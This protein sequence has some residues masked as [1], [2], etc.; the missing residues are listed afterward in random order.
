MSNTRRNGRPRNNAAARAGI[1]EAYD[2]AWWSA[3]RNVMDMMTEGATT[4]IGLNP[5]DLRRKALPALRRIQVDLS[6]S[7]LHPATQTR[8]RD[9]EIL[10]V[11]SDRLLLRRARSTAR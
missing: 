6:E 4:H 7:L 5:Q 11:L 3:Y 8:L 9:R 10:R 1:A 2:A